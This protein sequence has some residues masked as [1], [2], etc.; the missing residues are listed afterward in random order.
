MAQ[1]LVCLFFYLL[2]TKSLHSQMSVNNTFLVRPN[3]FFLKNCTNGGAFT[4][5]FFTNRINGG[6][7]AKD[8]EKF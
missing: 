4:N 3:L 1:E 8:V 2:Q 6:V 5:L 7:F